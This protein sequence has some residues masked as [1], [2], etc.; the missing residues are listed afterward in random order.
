VE[1]FD[2]GAWMI[3]RYRSPAFHVRAV[4]FQWVLV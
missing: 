3:L 2:A 1:G 4:S